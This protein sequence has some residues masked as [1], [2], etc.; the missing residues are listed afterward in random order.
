MAAPAPDPSIPE[1]GMDLHGHDVAEL[2]HQ[3]HAALNQL[4]DS[5]SLSPNVEYSDLAAYLEG[6]VADMVNMHPVDWTLDEPRFVHTYNM[7]FLYPRVDDPKA[8]LRLR[9]HAP[10]DAVPIPT[11]G[12]V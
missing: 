1:I 4:Q 9:L 5:N 7:R 3:V 6:I 8:V 10:A 2:R 12:Y 11:S